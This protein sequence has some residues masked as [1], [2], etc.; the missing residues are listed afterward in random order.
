MRGAKVG[1][2]VKPTAPPSFDAPTAEDLQQLLSGYEVSK[3]IGRGGMGAVYKG[4]HLR[5]NRDV[6]IK[7]LPCDHGPTGDFQERFIREA[8]AMAKLSHPAIVHVYDADEAGDFLYIE[9]EFVDGQDLDELMES[10]DLT[11]AEIMEIVPQIG[12]ALAFAHLHGVVHRDIKPANILRSHDGLVKVADFG[13]AKSDGDPTLATLTRSTISLGTPDYLAPEAKE[14]GLVRM[15]IT[16]PTST[17][18]AWC[19]INC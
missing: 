15:S 12:D 5:L 6:A 1:G 18:W 8:R 14:A 16:A 19:S 11:T 10:G 7:I 4:R 17:L 2:R 13:L 3:L 9:M